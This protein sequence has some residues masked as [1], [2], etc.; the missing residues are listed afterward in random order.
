MVEKRRSKTISHKRG[1]AMVEL[2]FS[3]VIMG[4]V[5]L[6]APMLIQQSINSG[7]IALQ[8]EAIVA[9][10]SQT[11]VVLSM[12]WDENN[13]SNSAVSPMLDIDRAPFD[14]DETTTPLGLKDGVAGRISTSTAGTT[15]PP[16]L[17]ADF[18]ID[19]TADENTTE[20]DFTDFDDVD[21]YDNSNFS[22]TVF[23]SETTTADVGDYIDVNITMATAINYAEDRVSSVVPTNTIPLNGSTLNLNNNINK[24]AL[25]TP[26]NIKFIRVNLTSNSGIKELEKNITFEA[27]SCNIGTSLP[28]GSNHL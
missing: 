8:Q 16:T 10:A 25:T 20:L 6:S 19:P 22:L 21:D 2:I 14:F 4:I 1:I 11:S 26:S 23:N 13:N 28:Q 24:N 5:L 3:L 9:A 12:H 17:P 18:G 7:N 27:F 15:L